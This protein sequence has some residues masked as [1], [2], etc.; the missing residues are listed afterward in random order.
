MPFILCYDNL[1]GSGY[2]LQEEKKNHPVSQNSKKK[3][4]N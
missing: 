3:K 1:D 4:K 2:F